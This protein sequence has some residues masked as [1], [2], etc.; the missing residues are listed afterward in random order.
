M[1][2]TSQCPKNKTE[3]YE[4]S[5][6]IGCGVD[7]YGNNRYMCLPNE[8]KSSLVEFC[9]NGVM[10]IEE[11]GKQIEIKKKIY[12]YTTNLSY[13]RCVVQH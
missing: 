13:K 12:I 6:G 5:K 8:K 11:K 10:G 2:L 7:D 4:A 1:A 9:F 3:V